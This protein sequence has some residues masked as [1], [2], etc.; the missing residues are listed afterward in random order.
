MNIVKYETRHYLLPHDRFFGE[1]SIRKRFADVLEHLDL[2][3][4]LDLV[5]K[6][7]SQVSAAVHVHF[8]YLANTVI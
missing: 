7:Q 2:V 8:R 3:V 5:K 6:K 4:V 1:G